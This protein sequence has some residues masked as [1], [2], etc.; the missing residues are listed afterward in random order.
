M[1]SKIYTV[2]E[3]T[4][5]IRDDLEFNYPD[6]WVSGEISNLRRPASGHCYFTLKDAHAQLRVVLWRSQALLLRF[7]L[8]DGLEL[9]AHGAL[10]LYEPRGEYQLVADR[11]E[12]RGLGALQLAFDQLRARLEAEGLFDPIR[13][14]ILPRIPRRIALIT[15][16]SG[17]AVR[18]FL[19][20]MRRRFAGVQ[21]LVLPVR[22]QGDGAAAEIAAAVASANRIGGFD[23]L[24]VCR[25]GGSL[26]DLWA[27]N[28]ETVVRAL[29]ASSIPT[30]SAVGHEVDVTLADLVA[31]VRAPTPSAAAEMLV[32]SAHELRV[33]LGLLADRLGGAGRLRLERIR[34]RIE[35]LRHHRALELPRR[36]ISVRIQ[37]LDELWAAWQRCAVARFESERRRLG[38]AAAN[39]ERLDPRH[40]LRQ[41]R[42]RLITAGVRLGERPR[43]H[44]GLRRARLELAGA[45]LEGLNPLKVLARGYSVTFHDDRRTIVRHAGQV[46]SDEPLWV[47]L[48]RGWLRC[49]LIQSQIDP[50]DSIDGI[51]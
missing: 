20:V 41:A 44:V 4:R 10:S 22:V 47:R 6:L 48:H 49:R 18:D 36:R 21:V 38:A 28:E 7:E 2:E 42:Q 26:E 29:A 40:R 32:A 5:S 17:A 50:E 27:F 46:A 30:I 25:G 14:R 51:Q 13:K 16:P 3:L 11:I 9:L 24:V 23:A 12:P 35:R 15:S 43:Y 33:R 8:Q 34:T 19:K 31:D 1:P 39:L 37:R 45:R